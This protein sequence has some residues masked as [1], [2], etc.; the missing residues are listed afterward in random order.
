MK[1]TMLLILVGGLLLIIRVGASP[2]SLQ[3]VGELQSRSKADGQWVSLDYAPAPAANP[4]KGFMPFYD[5]YGSADKP[6][7]D[8]F[9]H[10]MGYF[11]V[12]PLDLMHRPNSFS[13]EMGVEPEIKTNV[14]R[15]DV[16][17]L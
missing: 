15:G 14:I 11:C 4:L 9:A 8:D 17:M 10:S 12:A 3:P 13:F 6:N 5:A 2:L 1:R 7:S 16:H